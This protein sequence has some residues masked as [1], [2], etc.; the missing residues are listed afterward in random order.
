MKN[1]VV[2]VILKKTLHPEFLAPK[3]QSVYIKL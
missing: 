3:A 1:E 2:A